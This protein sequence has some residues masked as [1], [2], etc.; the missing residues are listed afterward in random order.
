[1]TGIRA[2]AGST[3]MQWAKLHAAAKYNLAT[4]GMVSFPLAELGVSIDQLEINGP[5]V[6]GYEPLLQGLAERY[7]VPRKNIVTAMGT[8]FANQ[9]ALAAL[10]EPG[11]E[12]VIEN[13]TY[14]PLLGIAR[15]LG[16]EIR[17]F[18]RNAEHN[19]ALDVEDLARNLGPRTRVIVLCN[20]HNPS[21]AISSDSELKEIITLARKNNAFVLVDE[22]YLEMLFESAPRS[23]FHLDPER[24]VVT[25]SLTKAYGLSGVRCGWVFAPAAIVQRMWR[26][27]DLHAAGN[28]FP[29]E[30]LS[31]IAL[32]KLEM[33]SAK[34]SNSLGENR[35]LLKTFLE[36][37]DDLDYFW[38]EFGT[39]VFPRLKIGSVDD[40]C[41]LL[42]REFD[43]TVVPGKF[44]EL[45]DRFRIGVG[46]ATESVRESLDQLSRGLDAYKASAAEKV[47]Q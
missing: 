9:L 12:V 13:P 29:A 8:S 16:L 25:S 1:V 11:D 31:V 21:G 19:F 33:I 18:R 36:S 35:R 47:S 24:V 44:F 34:M 22:V 26:I 17:R 20:F 14:D 37:R 46:L 27:H 5:N 39:I 6:Y 4:S 10:T 43:T 40:L 7:R 15:Y 38:P 42:R 41:T 3:Y 45:P 32:Q 2:N 30:Q 28:P 23:A